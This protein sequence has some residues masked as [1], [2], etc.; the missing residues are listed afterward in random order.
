MK[1]STAALRFKTLVAVICLPWLAASA[2]ASNGDAGEAYRIGY[3]LILDE[4]WQASIAAFDQL[5]AEHPASDWADD[6]AFWRCYARQQLDRPA[7]ELF[8]CYDQLLTRHAESEWA[9]DA[10]RAMV[11][12]ARQ[13]DREGRPE[14]QDK[15]RGFGQGE[16]A[17][18]LL[19]V[20]VALGEIGD[21]RSVGVI[22]E[23]L[24]A[25]ED[26][27][28]RARIVEV[29][30]DVDDRRAVDKLIELV[31]GDPSPRVRLAAI[32]ALSDHDSADAVGV[33]RE[34][35]LDREQP[36]GVRAEALD[37]ISDHQPPWLLGFLK[38]LAVGDDEALAMAA[39]EELGDLE[40]EAAVAALA[41]LLREA[42]DVRRRFEIVDALGDSELDSAV[43][44]LLEAAGRDPDPRVRRAATEALGDVETPAAREALIQLLKEIDD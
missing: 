37:E 33:L 7:A 14:Y 43:E 16:D 9:D 13:L 31:R 22:L 27:H 20:L 40:S 5:I 18:R 42:S 3:D 8:D 35:V 17:D 32:D 30:E 23:R 21:Q 36:Q 26:E 44:P 34:I 10:R 24:D 6:A 29:L 25:T 39:I 1:I 12:L 4:D 28:L 11:R 2:A 19:A 38:Q 15:V 41:G